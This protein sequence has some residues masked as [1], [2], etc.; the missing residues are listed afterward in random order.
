MKRAGSVAQRRRALQSEIAVGRATRAAQRRRLRDD[1]G[2]A[3][4]AMTATRLL[5][6]RWRWAGVLVPVAFAIIG[7]LRARRGS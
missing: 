2:L 1:A 4:L 7:A 6:R 5:A 3:V